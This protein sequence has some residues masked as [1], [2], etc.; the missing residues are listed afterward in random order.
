MA[1]A[2]EELALRPVRAL[3]RL[4][5]LLELRVGAQHCGSALADVLFELRATFRQP[6]R[7]EADVESDRRDEGEQGS[8]AERGAL[9]EMGPHDEA[10][11][12]LGRRPRAPGGP[13][14]DDEA[15]RARRDVGV[16]RL[17]AR[18]CLG[19]LTLESLE[20]IAELDVLGRGER[21][22]HEAEFERDG[23]GTKLDG[24]ARRQRDVIREGLVD[25]RSRRDDRAPRLERVDRRHAAH[26]RVPEAPIGSARYCRLRAPVALA[27]RHPIRRAE[28]LD[29]NAGRTA[30][31][32]L[33]E[34]LPVHALHTEVGA[35][36]EE[37]PLVEVERGHDAVLE[38]LLGLVGEDGVTVNAVE[39]ATVR[40]EPH[41]AAFVDENG[42]DAQIGH[43]FFGAVVA[44]DPSL[45]RV[46]EEEPLIG[47]DP[48]A[49]VPGIDDRRDVGIVP[50]LRSG[51]RDEAIAFEHVQ[52]APRGADPHA[53]GRVLV[54]TEDPVGAQPVLRVVEAHD[55]AV[56]PRGD[57][58][59]E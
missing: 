45:V 54:D 48:Q 23:P 20:P 37:A 58:S 50:P 39:P 3:R 35:G 18:A 34:L 21:R 36:P 10:E 56:G 29:G 49:A 41:D 51:S 31:S 7:A 22:S 53:P 52:A 12:F 13:C 42:A 17:A 2:R 24:A 6:A 11:R 26:R 59:P 5:R 28:G 14:F 1:H 9:V 30:R 32:H 25:E 4:L 47:P 38:P 27:R 43:P 46:V 8:H 15:I 44:H 40:P 16:V 55:A 33:V 19:P 57:P